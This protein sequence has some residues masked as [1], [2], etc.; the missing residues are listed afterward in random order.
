MAFEESIMN[1][2]IE[3]TQAD[4]D[5]GIISNEMCPVALA[6]R[7]VLRDRFPYVTSGEFMV[8]GG[9]FFKLPP[10]VGKFIEAFDRDDEVEPLSFALD[11]PDDV[12][13]ERSPADG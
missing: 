1:V 10:R 11:L 4:I 13:T 7:R 12:L 5:K 6:L 2:N 8:A 9:R 3:V